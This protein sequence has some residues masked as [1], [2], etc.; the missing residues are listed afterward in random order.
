[1]STLGFSK[2]IIVSAVFIALP[3]N[4]QGAGNAATVQQIMKNWEPIANA[5]GPVADIAGANASRLQAQSEG[6]YEPLAVTATALA[7]SVANTLGDKAAGQAATLIAQHSN[8]L[9]EVAWLKSLADEIPSSSEAASFMRKFSPV[10]E[11]LQQQAAKLS[12]KG[13]SL[14]VAGGALSVGTSLYAFNGKVDGY[15][16]KVDTGNA[17]FADH[18]TIGKDTIVTAWSAVP[19]A[20]TIIGATD[21]AVDGAAWG[22][23]KYYDKAR[24]IS[25]EFDRELRQFSSNTRTVIRQR[26]HETAEEGIS[27]STEQLIHI[28]RKQGEL[29]ERIVRAHEDS[30]PNSFFDGDIAVKAYKDTLEFALSLQ[31]ISPDNPWLKQL[32]IKSKELALAYGIERL[33][34]KKD[35]LVKSIDELTDTAQQ[36]EQFDEDLANL[37]RITGE[38][39]VQPDADPGVVYSEN[40]D[41]QTENPREDLPALDYTSQTDYQEKY[42]QQEVESTLPH[43]DQYDG[44]SGSGAVEATNITALGHISRIKYTGP[45]DFV[46]LFY[47]AIYDIEG[48]QQNGFMQ[49]NIRVDKNYSVHALYEY[50]T[51]YSYTEWGYWSST[52]DYLAYYD[53]N[54]GYLTIGIP[55]PEVDLL[56]IRGSASYHGKVIGSYK[57][58]RE[59]HVNGNIDLTANF[60]T[61]TLEGRLSLNRVYALGETD[62]LHDLE[63]SSLINKDGKYGGNLQSGDATVSGSLQGRFYGPNAKETG[64]VFSYTHKETSNTFGANPEIIHGA[65]KANKIE[66]R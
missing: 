32:E 11:G 12:L 25:E 5:V 26:L 36:I 22:I 34:T 63:F 46:D 54:A 16:S 30:V 60:D 18:L 4:V 62:K 56:N 48:N 15:L 53:G 61:D 27:L 33:K 59:G 42:A 40:D 64:G 39:E 7:G 58:V 21:L 47:L 8:Y 24:S 55:T 17:S 20:G 1:M 51:N 44:G 37:A 29:L 66:E 13:N 57:G 28:I 65:F 35:A 38:L 19:V 9:D 49:T 2:K 14:K 52:A 45:S 50:D 10:D 41:L 43:S 23:D 31:N 3:L 6:S